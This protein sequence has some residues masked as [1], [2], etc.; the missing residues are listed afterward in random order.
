MDDERPVPDGRAG[1]VKPGLSRWAVASAVLAWTSVGLVSLLPLALHFS[2][3]AILIAL[4]VSPFLAAFLATFCGLE[5]I[6][7]RTE[8]YS[9]VSWRSQGCLLVA[10]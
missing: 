9:A 2:R 7:R 8:L 5:A 6:G 3:A 4:V 10:W 1:P